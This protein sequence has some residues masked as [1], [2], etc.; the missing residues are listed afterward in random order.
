MPFTSFDCV[1]ELLYLNHNSASSWFAGLKGG[2]LCPVSNGLGKVGKGHGLGI[3]A[4]A[5][6]GVVII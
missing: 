1:S 5:G 6:V 4:G 2:R 3:G